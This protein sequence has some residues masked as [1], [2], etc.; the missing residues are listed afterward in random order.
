MESS[1]IVLI[2]VG[3]LAV[4]SSYRMLTFKIRKEKG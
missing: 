2:I 4:W 3:I 1:T